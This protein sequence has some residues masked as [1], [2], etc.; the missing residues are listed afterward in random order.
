MAGNDNSP[1]VG[2]GPR[3]ETLYAAEWAREPT[4]QELDGGYLPPNAPER[5]RPCGVPDRPAE[6]GRGLRRARKLAARLTPRQRGAPGRV[7]VPG[8]AAAQ[9]RPRAGRRMGPHPHRLFEHAEFRERWLALDAGL[10][11]ARRLIVPSPGCDSNSNADDRS[12][13]GQ[14]KPHLVPSCKSCLSYL[15]PPI[16]SEAKAPKIPRRNSAPAARRREAT[17]PRDTICGS[18]GPQKQKRLLFMHL[19]VGACSRGYNVKWTSQFLGTHSTAALPCDA[20]IVMARLWPVPSHGPGRALGTGAPRASEGGGG[21]AREPT[22][23]RTAPVSHHSPP[24]TTQISLAER[25]CAAYPKLCQARR[26]R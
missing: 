13:H 23:H 26:N 12:R 4:D 2:R 20:E 11:L 6:P 17:S 16:G 25:N 19:G 15:P 3:G 22:R 5:L 14:R 24:R 8:Q 9:E 1:V 21:P 18:R 10:A 7:A